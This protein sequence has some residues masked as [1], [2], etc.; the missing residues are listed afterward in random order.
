MDINFFALTYL[1]LRLA[2]FILVSFFSIS[3]IFNQDFKGIV[4]LITLLASTFIVLLCESFIP[5][6]F[7]LPP[8]DKD[9]TCDF[10]NINSK[11]FRQLVVSSFFFVFSFVFAC[12]CFVRF[13]FR[14]DFFQIKFQLARAGARRLGGR[15]PRSGPIPD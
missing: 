14:Y 1:F 2:P 12:V 10:L 11:Y 7:L 6:S 3:S 8:N 5:A 13:R 9:L 4:Y 15:T